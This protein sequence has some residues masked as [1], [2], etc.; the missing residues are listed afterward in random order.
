DHPSYRLVRVD[1]VSLKSDVFHSKRLFM[2]KKRHRSRNRPCA[3]VGSS[4][5]VADYITFLNRSIFIHA[6]FNRRDHPVAHTGRDGILLPRV[7]DLYRP[8]ALEGQQASD[9]LCRENIRSAAERT[10]N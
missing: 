10:T 8:L 9:E 2:A 7:N 3:R 5:E 4:I 1:T 6:G